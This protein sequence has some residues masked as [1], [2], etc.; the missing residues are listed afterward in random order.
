MWIFATG[1]KYT[2]KR[3]AHQQGSSKITNLVTIKLIILQIWNSMFFDNFLSMK[4]LSYRVRLM[5]NPIFTFRNYL[6]I[7]IQ[8]TLLTTLI[9]LEISHLEAIFKWFFP[10]TMCD[11]LKPNIRCD[12]H[13]LIQRINNHICTIRCW[14]IFLVL[15]ACSLSIFLFCRMFRGSFNLLI[16]FPW[17]WTV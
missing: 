17:R 4:Y 2:G 3:Y 7:R 10:T 13:I 1:V 5:C 16:V 8:N 11:F 9:H 6:I 14:C 15:I 12:R